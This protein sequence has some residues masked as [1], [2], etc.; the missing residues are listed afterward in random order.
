[1]ILG[2]VVSYYGD[3]PRGLQSGWTLSNWQPWQP[4]H[5]DTLGFWRG[6]QWAYRLPVF[7]AFLIFCAAT[8]FWPRPKNLAHVLALSTAVLIGT[9]FW[10]TDQGGV[11][12]LWYLPFLLLMVFRPNLTV[13]MPPPL[14]DDWLTRLGRAGQRLLQRLFQRPEPA[15]TP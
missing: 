4:P 3:W 13:C 12:V 11:Y 14:P 9:Q 2:L 8:L 6:L 10:Y 15:A 7:I 1:V 5:P